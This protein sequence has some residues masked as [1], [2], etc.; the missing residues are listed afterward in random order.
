MIQGCSIGCILLIGLKVYRYLFPCFFLLPV[1]SFY[2][3]FV[4]FFLTHQVSATRIWYLE[5]MLRSE[6]LLKAKEISILP[7][8]SQ[9]FWVLI[10][11]AFALIKG[12]SKVLKISAL[13]LKSSSPGPSTELSVSPSMFRWFWTFSHDESK[14]IISL[15]V[16]IF[17]LLNRK[18]NI[19]N[20]LLV[21]SFV[22]DSTLGVGM[23]INYIK[24]TCCS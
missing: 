18:Y 23:K 1:L 11:S 4:I 12:N 21:T 8:F 15:K 2:C 5:L 14:K 16:S 3:L 20:Y 22:H 19:C 9:I 6:T 10:I 24:F 13:G 7:H 17:I